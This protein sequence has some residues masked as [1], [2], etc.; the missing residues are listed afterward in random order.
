MK[1]I[2]LPAESI[3]ISKQADV[4]VIG[5]GPS[6]IAAAIASARNGAKTLLIEQR[7]YLGGMGTVSLVPA[8]CPFT[9]K[10]KPV[11]RG[12]GLELLEQMKQ[13]CSAEYQR[14]YRSSLDW[15]P[16]D[17]EVLKRVYDEAVLAC[18]VELL[19]HTFVGQIVKSD[20]DH[21]VHTIVVLNKSGRSAIEAKY[22][23]DATGDAD[24]AA[25]A[26]A[27]FQ[28]GGSAGEMQPGTMCY[29]VTNA[30]RKAFTRYLKESG[31]SGQIHLAVEKAQQAGDLPAGRKKVSGF[32]WLSDHLVG[33]NFGHVFGVDGTKA[34]DLTKGAV[35][36]RRLAKIQVDFLRRYVPGF[37]HAHLTATGEQIGIRETRRIVGDYILTEDDFVNTR[38]FADDIARNAYFIDVH[39]ATSGDQMSIYRLPPG[40]SHGVPYRCLLPKGL[41]NVWVAGRSA[42]ADRIV[43]SSLRVMPNCFAMGQAA[44]TAAALAAEHSMTSRDVPIGRLQ[45]R[46]V[47]Q[48]AW[49]GDR[50]WDG[51]TPI[52][53]EGVRL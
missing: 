30:D 35:E 6:G 13:N 48:G 27:P 9:D 43:Q 33:V 5:G 45:E 8:F 15:V 24:I 22:V 34:E 17:P 14:M 18:G 28:K 44:G 42:S 12:I 46:L 19:Y 38:S 50:V 11:I 37:E 1:T 7:G 25:L 23:I 4:V 29:L 21:H 31:D 3:P 41:D 51:E 52:H 20:D 40:H 32:A 39:L 36:G 53:Q 49:L 47:R 10:E 2:S 26:G 16:I